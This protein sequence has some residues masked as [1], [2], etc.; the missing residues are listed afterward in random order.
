MAP[1]VD[2]L[3]ISI[4]SSYTSSSITS[5]Y[6]SSSTFFAFRAR[7]PNRRRAL[8]AAAVVIIVVRPP[9]I[10]MSTSRPARWLVKFWPH[11]RSHEASFGVSLPSA[12]EPPD[13][14]S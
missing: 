7:R 8:A 14:P 6:T 5:S 3:A 12:G 4:T 13:R 1:F 10:L 9:S 11:R 2:L